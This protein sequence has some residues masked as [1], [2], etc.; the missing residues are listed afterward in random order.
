MVYW[1][2]R[3]NSNLSK[4]KTTIASNSSTPCPLRDLKKCQ[5]LGKNFL[6]ILQF[7]ETTTH[8]P[9]HIPTHKHRPMTSR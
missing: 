8:P 6:Q 2:G 1:T 5:G 9:T 7:L 4:L 3:I